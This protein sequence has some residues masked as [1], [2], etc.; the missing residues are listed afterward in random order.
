MAGPVDVASRGSRQQRERLL[1][2]LERDDLAAV[3]VLSEL[4][5]VLPAVRSYVDHHRHALEAR[6]NA[7]HERSGTRDL[8][9]HAVRELLRLPREHASRSVELEAGT[10]RAWRQQRQRAC[11]LSHNHWPV[12]SIHTE[13]E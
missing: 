5:C 6:D 1:E 10:R 13:G 8:E 2:W 12:R 3:T 11:R 7:G 9:A 4:G